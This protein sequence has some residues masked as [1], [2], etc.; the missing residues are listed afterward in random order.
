MKNYLNKEG[1]K[2]TDEAWI[3]IDMDEWSSEQITQIYEWSK[4]KENYGLAVS[5]PMFEFWL[6]L[7]FED[8]TKIASAKECLERLKRHLP[9]YRKGI[10]IRKF[11]SEIIHNA[12]RRAK[13][14]DNPMCVDWPRAIGGTTV[15]RL[16]EKL[17]ISGDY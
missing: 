17:I 13:Q 5:N 14:R 16:V 15:Y 11:T 7:H 12:V 9:E 2:K 4:S 8:G 6:L 3:V 1:L 10:D